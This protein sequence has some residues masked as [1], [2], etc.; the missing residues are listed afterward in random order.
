MPRLS[1]PERDSPEADGG[2]TLIELL[3]VVVIIGIMTAVATGSFGGIITSMNN[4]MVAAN[5]QAVRVGLAGYIVASGTVPKDHSGHAVALNWI[6]PSYG[7]DP[8]A[9]NA[10]IAPLPS[11]DPQLKMGY[12]PFCYWVLGNS[13]H[14]TGYMASG[15]CTDAQ[16]AAD[17]SGVKP[18][19]E[20]DF[21]LCGQYGSSTKYLAD[22]WHSV[23]PFTSG[24]KWPDQTV[25]NDHGCV[26]K[27]LSDSAGTI[28]VQ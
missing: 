14:P 28:P 17:G 5:M 26:P 11:T 2:F 24:A 12:V 20:T 15:M 25:M 1:R 4:S 6:D 16:A 21:V 23:Q 8:N 9:I 22:T 18:L 13:V 7:T 19:I 27:P 3:V 10:F